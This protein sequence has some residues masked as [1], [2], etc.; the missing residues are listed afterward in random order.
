[1]CPGGSTGVSSVITNTGTFNFDTSAAITCDLPLVNTGRLNVLQGTLE[2]TNRPDTGT[3][4][5]S[6]TSG[7]INIT[8]GASLKADY[9]TLINGGTLMTV[10]VGTA[11]LTGD[12]TVQQGSIQLGT[13][14]NSGHGTLSV[15][16]RVNLIGTSLLKVDVDGSGTAC[17]QIEAT[18]TITLGGSA[19]L[20][21]VV[22]PSTG[23][24]TATHVVL[25][26]YSGIVGDFGIKDPPGY[27]TSIVAD[28]LF[29]QDY[30]LTPS[31]GPSGG[32]E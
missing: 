18:G 16:G 13:G 12:L 25:W 5:I 15:T 2:F 7:G 27:A 23:E 22:D 29:G 1:M 19:K 30:L 32:T 14:L 4:S 3:Y 6:Q 26:S 8:S 10:G 20:W 17:D 21:A 9:D 24:E 11:Y 31:G 28:P